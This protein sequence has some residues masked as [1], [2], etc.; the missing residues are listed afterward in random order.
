MICACVVAT[1][2]EPVGTCRGV[3]TEGNPPLRHETNPGT[4]RLTVPPLEIILDPDIA[5]ADSAY[6]HELLETVMP[7]FLEVLGPPTSSQPL[8]VSIQG[9]NFYMPLYHYLSMDP[10][11]PGPNHDDDGDGYLD[12][13]PHDGRDNDG[14]DLV[15]E[16]PANSNVWDN[17]FIHE[18]S[19][20]F[21]R[22]LFMELYIHSWLA[23]ALAE[24]GEY[25]V[26]RHA[27]CHNPG[28]DLVLR[29]WPSRIAISDALNV[30]AGNVLGGIQRLTQRFDAYFTY[31]AAGPVVVLPMLAEL[32]AGRDT[33][34]PMAALTR[35]LAELAVEDDEVTIDAVID[36][37]W[38]TPLD[39]IFPPS[40]WMHSRSI[41]NLW[42]AA[43]IHMHLIPRYPQL[44]MNPLQ[45]VSLV[46]RAED[47]AT[48]YSPTDQRSVTATATNGASWSLP[49]D[50]AVHEVGELPVG[51]YHLHGTAT[52]AGH[53]TS[54]DN[55]ILMTNSGDDVVRE[56]GAVAVI[57]VGAEGYPVDPVV[58][59]V[60]GR[61]LESVPGGAIVA[62]YSVLDP[63]VALGF[64][65][66][67]GHVHSVTL[68]GAVGR[69]VPIFLDGTGA[70]GSVNWSPYHPEA[71]ENV[72]IRLRRE[73]SALRGNESAVTC[74]FEWSG[75][76]EQHVTMFPSD[77]G[78]LVANIPF[79]DGPDRVNLYFEDGFG[80]HGTV[81]PDRPDSYRLIISGGG[82]AADIPA[83]VGLDTS[84]LLAEF[85]RPVSSGE[86]RLD[87][88][89]A[90]T[91]DWSDTGLSSVT[92]D[93]R[94]HTWDL[95][96]LTAPSRIRLVQITS[97]EDQVLFE[98][99]LGL[100][101]P[102]TRILDGPPFPNPTPDGLRWRVE[103]DRNATFA[104]TVHDLRGRVVHGPEHM[105]LL[106]G[107]REIRWNGRHGDRHLPAGTYVLRLEGA[108]R[109]LTR[110]A[111]IMPK[112]WHP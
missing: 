69:V 98:G 3:L 39:G 58:L 24:A 104:F 68:A 26:G 36:R 102:T 31:M 50:G 48:A 62:P 79:P 9:G 112:R 82:P 35:A 57:F 47:G 8:Y 44:A 105:D 93:D 17:I 29:D 77:D 92:L 107:H 80:L 10:I 49:T 43:G 1:S 61:V 52:V 37:A 13:D 97:R 76:G 91:T 67:D 40:R 90:G 28:R 78:T 100:D 5:A 86:L 73:R 66:G 65:L 72:L 60:D 18:L 15:D 46:V 75:G 45:L 103:L 87:D 34:H 109:V 88:R 81:D 55:W 101:K 71:G 84:R 4:K 12:E 110:S 11:Y 27:E 19:H 7:S 16:D 94:T 59:H 70:S 30:R 89:P 38:R 63:P 56:G 64:D 42:P 95:T 74:S 54:C 14:D 96:G 41:A 53:M 99:A 21:H 111:T 2:A 106:A 51:A 6:L 33:P 20:A 85:E 25:F 108:G 22:Q 32:A 23:E 83:V